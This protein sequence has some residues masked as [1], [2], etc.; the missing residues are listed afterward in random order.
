M[1]QEWINFILGIIV[2]IFAY[3]GAGATWLAIAGVLIVI[4]SLWGALGSKRA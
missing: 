1:W 3:S 4:F 2:L